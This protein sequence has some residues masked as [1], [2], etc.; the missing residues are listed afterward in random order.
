MNNSRKEK[1]VMW[2]FQN[3]KELTYYKGEKGKEKGKGD[4]GGGA[5]SNMK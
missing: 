1:V 5:S 2:A 4:G 3:E